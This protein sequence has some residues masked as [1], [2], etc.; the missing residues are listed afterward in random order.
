MRSLAEI[1]I[2]ITAENQQAINALRQLSDAANRTG[3]DLREVGSSNENSFLGT[4]GKIGMI[5]T[6]TAAA[7]LGV[8]TAIEGTIGALLKY[9]SSLEQD[10]I[11]FTTMLGSAEAAKTFMGDIQQ[12][13]AD[14]PFELPQL[15]DA[16]KKMLAFGFAAKDVIPTLTSIGNAVAGLGGNSEMIDRVT[17]AIGQMRVK[18][19]VS[20]EELGQ[21]AEA[22]IPA[23]S[24][25]AEKLHLTGKQ[26]ANIGNESI[27]ADVAIQA[28]VQGMNEKFPNMMKKQ[29]ESMQGMVSTIK[30]NVM[31]IGSSLTL[32]LSS[33]LGEGV[34]AFRDFTNKAAQAVKEGNLSEIIIDLVP[35][36]L[37][38]KISLVTQ[39]SNTCNDTKTAV[40]NLYQAIK[41]VLLSFGDLF[42]SCL[43]A[44]LQIIDAI[45][46]IANAAAPALKSALNLVAG[47]INL[48]SNNTNNLIS[49][50]AVLVVSW[51]TLKTAMWAVAK[52]EVFTTMATTAIAAA[53]SIRSLRGAVYLL[54]LAMKNLS[55]TNIVLLLLTA[56]GMMFGDKI[57]EW[58]ESF[59]GK[60]KTVDSIEPDVNENND[61]GREAVNNHSGTPT[62]DSGNDEKTKQ[63]KITAQSQ[64]KQLQRDMDSAVKD[65]QKQ[66]EELKI[67]KQQADLTGTTIPDYETKLQALQAQTSQVKVEYLEKMK[68][69]TLAVA[70]AVRSQGGKLEDYQ[71]YDDQVGELNDRIRDESKTLKETGV[72]IKEVQ[73]IADAT[74]NGAKEL[75]QLIIKAGEEQLGLTYQLGGDGTASTDCGKFVQDTLSKIGINLDRRTAD[76]QFLQLE[77]QGKT[78][79]DQINLKIGD[80]VYFDVPSN[81]D[82]WGY[83]DSPDAVNRND[84]AYKGITHTGIYAGDGRVL[85]AGSHGV[86]YAELSDFGKIVGYGD[87]VGDGTLSVTQ[88]QDKFSQLKITSQAAID[89]YQRRH[90]LLK[91]ADEAE[92]EMLQKQNKALESSEKAV[93]AQYK[94]LIEKLKAYGYT[95]KV[96]GVLKLIDSKKLQ[97]DFTQVQKDLEIVNGEL[98]TTQDNLINDLASGTKTAAQVTQEYADTYN[99]KTEEEV[100]EL[101]EEL[102]KAD[103]IE[104]KELANHIRAE[105]RKI[106]NATS[107]FSE[108]TIQRVNSDL[109]NEINRINANPNLTSMQKSD[110]IEAAQRRAYNQ[111]ADAQMVDAKN[112]TDKGG[113]KSDAIALEE[114]A[115]LNH[116]YGKTPS[117]LDKIHISGKQAFED[118]LLT[119]LTT[120][121]TECNN[122]GEAFRNLANSVLQSIQ[123]IYAE[124]VTKNI[125]SMLNLGAN[126]GTKGDAWTLSSGEKLDPTFGFAEGGNVQGPGTGT[127]DSILARLSNGEFVIKA[128][129]VQKYGA[130]FLHR[131]NNGFVPRN[132]TPRFATG[133]LVGA[134]ADGAAGIASSIQG[135]DVSVPLKVINVTDPNEVGRYLSTRSGE[136]V[137]VNFMKNNAGVMRQLLNIKG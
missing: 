25:L 86:S 99:K 122:L 39:F 101:Q 102:A 13:A 41:P 91:Q 32:G 76:A 20:A 35:D 90:D 36:G 103:K 2:Q 77:Q 105:L 26:V 45:M 135:G 8:K 116:E 123:K 42:L 7:I 19:H 100:A 50:L 58:A 46:N 18:G 125:M 52:I 59:S 128:A 5:A 23:Y 51:G 33:K 73:N 28:L 88:L 74:G 53:R 108:K 110:A 57:I 114:A 107:E 104:N 49:G 22:G 68:N 129:S 112:I 132:L 63:I 98:I 70:G 27:N 67:Q 31:M 119:F 126:N 1:R 6:G 44:I 24:I 72:A 55:K 75:G 38:G 64:I 87:T 81:R 94:P 109:Q 61:T 21:L 133:G 47:A 56:G 137:M 17:L 93:D 121:I 37:K 85:Q 95:D 134:S 118:G 131:L 106:T 60:N 69:E 89:E 40:L 113:L 97:I 117:L 124:A 136:K 54:G 10:N 96:D 84:Q 111:I 66:I 83:S 34:R 43:P 11:A 62:P 14:T 48:V 30:D 16:S 71:Q 3:E 65:V 79:T 12:L 80:T 78:F 92:I 29:A 4:F 115:A 120:G 127:S 9:N 15:T 82:Q 130:N